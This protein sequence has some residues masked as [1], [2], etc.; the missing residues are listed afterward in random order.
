MIYANWRRGELDR[1]VHQNISMTNVYQSW[2]RIGSWLKKYSPAVSHPISG[3]IESKTLCEVQEKLGLELPDDL[4][5]SY[6]SH[7]P[8]WDELYTFAL[9]Y[10][11]DERHLDVYGV[12]PRV[13][14]VIP[15]Q[16]IHSGGS[17]LFAVIPPR[18]SECDTSP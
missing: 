10:S 1:C 6:P 17:V 7:N 4:R 9:P 12:I 14:G 18:N 5:E 13:Y 11:L 16:E 8:G 3:P 15:R 2:K